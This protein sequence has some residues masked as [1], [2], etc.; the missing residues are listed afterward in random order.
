MKLQTFMTV[1]RLIFYAHAHLRFRQVSIDD[2]VFLK[3]LKC[4]V[5]LMEAYLEPSRTSTMVLFLRKYLTT[6]N[7]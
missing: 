3:Y 7:C 4:R 6:G 1:A 5:M 2:Y